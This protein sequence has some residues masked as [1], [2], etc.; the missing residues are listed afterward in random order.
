MAKNP[1]YLGAK[2]GP[3]WE[4]SL[5]TPVIGQALASRLVEAINRT[6]ASGA[7]ALDGNVSWWLVNVRG[8]IRMRTY[9]DS[10]REAIQRRGNVFFLLPNETKDLLMARS[11]IRVAT[12]KVGLRELEQNRFIAQ[13]QQL[14]DRPTFAGVFTLYKPKK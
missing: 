1:E 7:I 9:V 14:V 6:V 8:E 12:N 11:I 4:G 10:I 5:V 2:I 13:D 3:A